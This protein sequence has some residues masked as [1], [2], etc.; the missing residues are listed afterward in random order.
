MIVLEFVC[1]AIV[2][3]YV[4]WR[5]RQTGDRRRF[6]TQLVLLAC[7]GWVAE[8]TV[9]HAYGFYSYSP[10]WSVFV[11][12]VPL[13]VLLIWPVVIHSAWGLTRHLDAHAS[14]RRVAIVGG[15]IVLSDASLIEPIAVAAGLWQWHE[16]GIF[17]VPPIGILGWAL[18]AA[19]CIYLL[20]RSS[21]HA[22]T[23]TRVGALLLAPAAWTHVSLLALW[24]AGFR[25]ANE[26]VPPNPVVGLAWVVSIA[27]TAAVVRARAWRLVP[28]NLL[29]QRIPA[30]LF[31][32]VLLGLYA[33]EQTTLVLYALAFAPPYL[34]LTD[35]RQV[36]GRT[37]GRCG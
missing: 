36:I 23:P 25:Q 28:S 1:A 26:T 13:M 32:F 5:G 27:L 21:D 30:A 18:F 11:D 6:L 4:V 34:A 15:A 7:A 24:W 8:D 29:V 31:F 2:C 9:I 20:E 12:Q 35:W 22:A 3:S 17:G 16:P 10:R 33:R 19:A 14:T 37:E